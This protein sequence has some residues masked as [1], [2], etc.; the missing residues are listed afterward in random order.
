MALH[1]RSTPPGTPGGI[2]RRTLIGGAVA[3][4][5]AVLL[6]ITGFLVFGGSGGPNDTPPAGAPAPSAPIDPATGAALQ[7]TTY[8]TIDSAPIDT[9]TDVATDGT[10]A[11]PVRATP[12]R[13]APNGTVVAMMPVTQFG[14]TWLPVIEKQPGWVHVL[15]P[16]KPNGST[17]WLL[18]DD[19]KTA[20]TPYL[21]KVHLTSR[22]LDLVKNGAL[23]GS[24]K[25]G[26]GKASAPTPTG[27]TFIL[28]AFSDPKQKYSPV[29][30]P[31]G[32]HSATHDSFGGG[33]GTV[34]IHT[35]PS[36]GVFGTASS[37]GCIRIPAD[38][39]TML[40]K[41]PLGTLVMIAQD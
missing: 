13:V 34:G 7:S 10:V 25:A 16:S 11:H 12:V 19:V 30:L 38:A 23:A 32:T 18:A 14:D 26:T 5:L 2:P 24:W 28:G 29:I 17:G 41:V 15:L 1:T 8:T 3:G 9:A 21:V 40:T 20:T 35:W 36:S 31:L 4:V 22:T 27:R 39:L 33:P 6:I 37:D